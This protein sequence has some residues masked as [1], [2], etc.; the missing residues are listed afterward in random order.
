[1]TSWAGT[2]TSHTTTA[3]TTASY[4]Q[5]DELLGTTTPAGR[6]ANIWSPRGTLTSTTTTPTSGAVSTVNQQFDSFDRL[7]QRGTGAAD[8]YN[9]DDL[10]RLAQNNGGGGYFL[11]DGLDREPTTNGTWTVLRGPDGQALA[12]QSTAGSGFVMPL[13]DTHGDVVAGV[14][15]ATGAVTGSRAFSTF[16]T[17]LASTGTNTP[18][19]YQGSWTDPTS[20]QVHADARWYDTTTGTFT[21]QDAAPAAATSAASANLY[22]YANANPTSNLDPTGNNGVS[23][24]VDDFWGIVNDGWD[25]AESTATTFADYAA[26][27]GETV[28]GAAQD[29]A[30]LA[31]TGG[32]DLVP[33]AG[34]AVAGLEVLGDVA[35]AGA[36]VACFPE[37]EIIGAVVL[38]TIDAATT[39]SYI[40]AGDGVELPASA[41]ATANT[42]GYTYAWTYTAD[43]VKTTIYEQADTDP[44]CFDCQ[45]SFYETTQVIPRPVATPAPKAGTSN[46]SAGADP[47]AT[48]EP[49]PCHGWTCTAP[50]GSQTTTVA[51]PP[52]TVAAPAPPPPPAKPKAPKP[53]VTAKIPTVPLMGGLGIDYGVTSLLGTGTAK[54]TTGPSTPPAAPPP[55]PRPVIDL[56]NPT[57][58]QF[59][60]GT[61]NGNN[62]AP[63]T[64]GGTCGD[65]GPLSS[66]EPTNDGLPGGATNFAPVGAG[67]GGDGGGTNGRTA[68]PAGDCDPAD[69]QCLAA[70]DAGGAARSLYRADSRAPDEIF[71]NGFTPKGNNMNLL[72][73]AEQNPADSGFVSTTHSLRS[74]QDFAGESQVDYIYKLRGTGIDVNAELGAA[75]SFP[76]ENEI[77]IPGSVP[78][79]SIEGVWGPGGWLGNPGFAP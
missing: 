25:W 17:V 32:A 57:A 66:C 69:A 42:N 62:P 31:A 38:V 20:G 76:W 18:I 43:G 22:A 74:A 75:S 78:G 26:E 35:G 52:A 34:E 11:Y 19:G 41:T 67:G 27:A 12:S 8:F 21:A 9:Y 71:S 7:V 46:A 63:S 58:V 10:D 39:Y 56:T 16:G 33:S 5:R 14:A 23:S 73:H 45:P 15:A 59:A 13:Q 36:A 37:C 79:G 72:Q 60:A 3:T 1:M 61:P 29:V 50:S 48:A 49:P 65:G 6:T 70:E 2:A 53:P 64:D 51:A 28:A 24:L 77:A 68:T 40:N 4:D 44:D 54:T 47:G 30:S 55:P